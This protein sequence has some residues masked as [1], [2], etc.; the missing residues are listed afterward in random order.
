MCKVTPGSQDYEPGN[1]EQMG[2]RDKQWLLG[3]SV[4]SYVCARR[5]PHPFSLL[6]TKKVVLVKER[7]RTV[8]KKNV[9]K[10]RGH[11]RLRMWQKNSPREAGEIRKAGRE[12]QL[13]LVSLRESARSSQRRAVWWKTHMPL[14]TLTVKSS[15]RLF[16]SVMLKIFP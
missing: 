8:R 16:S 1:Q 13:E 3:V 6:G 7:L 5:V 2:P 11:F 12:K 10:M 4:C 15:F 9:W 14:A